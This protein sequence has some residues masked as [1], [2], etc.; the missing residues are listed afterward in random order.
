ML[1]FCAPCFSL[2]ST[3]SL[4]FGSLVGPSFF[5]VWKPP[6]PPLLLL[7]DVDYFPFSPG[8]HTRWFLGFSM[9]RRR[10]ELVPYVQ[11]FPLGEARD[12]EKEYI[13]G[14][15]AFRYIGRCL[16]VLARAQGFVRSSTKMNGEQV[17]L[18]ISICRV[19]VSVFVFRYSVPEC[20]CCNDWIPIWILY[21]ALHFYS[22]L[23]T[24]K[25]RQYDN[26][27]VEMSHEKP[28]NLILDGNVMWMGKKCLLCGVT[29]RV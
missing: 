28:L 17:L 18:C 23:F 10:E 26:R 4:S 16:P 12:R 9:P 25:I 24:D 1:Y 2:L 6:P 20:I 7:R 5:R 27:R 19:V 22:Y 14:K 11:S 3:L 13:H 21:S 15:M 29:K 8:A